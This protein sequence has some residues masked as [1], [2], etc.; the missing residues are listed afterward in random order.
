MDNLFP[1]LSSPV[2][3]LQYHIVSTAERSGVTGGLV[4]VS[5]PLSVLTVFY[6][7][8]FYSYLL[9][10]AVESPSYTLSYSNTVCHASPSITWTASYFFFRSLLNSSRYVSHNFLSFFRFSLY[11]TSH[12]F[13]FPGW[14]HD[15]PRSQAYISPSSTPSS[16]SSC[17]NFLILINQ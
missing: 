8:L 4:L 1:C 16:P 15:T 17:C 6:C 5:L 10:S 14:R 12:P 9:S 11:I 3:L 7:H 13:P 2:C